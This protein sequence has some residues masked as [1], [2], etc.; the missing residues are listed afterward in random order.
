MDCSSHPSA[1]VAAPVQNGQNIDDSIARFEVRLNAAGKLRTWVSQQ[2]TI[3]RVGV[4]T[5]SLS[6]DLFLPLDFAPRSCE[7]FRR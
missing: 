6:T 7:F 2:L 4:K 5:E 3:F 1:V